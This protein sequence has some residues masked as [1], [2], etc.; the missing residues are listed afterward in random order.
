M[1]ACDQATTYM[2]GDWLSLCS[3]LP[4][5]PMGKGAPA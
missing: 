3:P 5:R 4:L 2:W 1:V